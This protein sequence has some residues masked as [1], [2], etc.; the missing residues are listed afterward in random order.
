MI[1]VLLLLLLLVVL[2]VCQGKIIISEKA[3]SLTDDVFACVT[4]D[5]WP[6][7][8]CDYGYCPWGTNSM[9][10]VNLSNTMILNSM[11]AFDGNVHLR[12][13]GSLGDF[14]T[15][16]IGDYDK[17]AYCTYDD[18]S[19]PT[20]T[21]HAGYELFSG[22]LKLDKW[23]AINN[24]ANAV[25]TDISF[26]IN[27]LYGRGTPGPCPPN[28]NCRQ[29]NSSTFN[30]QCC[31]NW[32]GTWDSSN[33]KNFMQYNKDKGYNIYAYEFGNELVGSKGI[34]S[35]FSPAE[36]FV[37]WKKF[38]DTVA[39]VYSD[40]QSM[41]L[42][43]IPDNSFMSDWYAEFLE[44]CQQENVR[45]VDIVT[46]HL[47]SLGAGSNPQVWENAMNATYLDQIKV[48]GQSVN[49][50]V[51]T[52]S[53]SS[54]IWI[55]EAGGAYNSGR[56]N[57]TN[58]FN[59]GFWFLD[60]LAL[61]AVNGHAT[62]C[63]QA[64]V[65]GFYSLL[66][67][68]SYEPNPDYYSFLLFSRLMGKEVLQASSTDSPNNLRIYS[69]CTKNTKGGVT[70]LVINLSETDSFTIDDISVGNRN[71]LETVREEYILSSSYDIATSTLQ[72]VLGSKNILLNKKPL[73][74][75]QNKVPELLPK[76]SFEKTLVV[77]PLTYG[78]VVFPHAKNSACV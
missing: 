1:R 49:Q 26:G 68:F 20:N 22:C 40:S 66:D 13:G 6:S 18:F 57:V 50:V 25:K 2:S 70:M 34:E 33:A 15:Y 11:L 45:P 23:D 75:K 36:Y 61:F 59:S 62:Y 3:I 67:N 42:V 29:G 64:F 32:T 74:V 39:E 19:E 28:T 65:G 52:T 63:R 30:D 7:S 8:K 14:V 72:E 73:V 24:F 69:H 41:P 9:L 53:P 38:I 27:G 43:V 77:E 31:T 35:H 4:M 12:L 5:Y 71:L 60:Q 58:A 76:I 51:S 10:N 16:D 17:T 55:G 78:F 54:K 46:H 44:L 21:T 56:D 48:L 37:D 47:Y